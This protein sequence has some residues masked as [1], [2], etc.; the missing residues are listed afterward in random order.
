MKNRRG[1]RSA[2]YAVGY[3]RPPRATQFAS[4]KSG[5][6]KGRPKGSRTVGAIL[7]DILRQKIAV[8]ENG[9]TR[10]LAALEVMLRRLVND[11]MRSD[12]KAMKLLLALV[13]RYADT[14]EAKVQLGELLA[15]DQM[16]LAQYLREPK[17]STGDL[18]E[19]VHSEEEGDD[20]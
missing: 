17:S 15:E 14:T 18:A 10:R 19:L 4:G 11:A 3:G 8:T 16:I 7:Q 6:P 12:A 9:K 2:D 1:S 13:D 20:D 5:N